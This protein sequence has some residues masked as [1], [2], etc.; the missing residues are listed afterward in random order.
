MVGLGVGLTADYGPAQQMYVKRG[1]I[2]DGR[3]LYSHDKPAQYGQFV[4]VD[5]DLVL[6]FTKKLRD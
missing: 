2:P 6:Y 1:Y 3:G 4:P 5:D